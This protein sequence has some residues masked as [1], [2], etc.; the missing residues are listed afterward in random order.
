M[1]FGNFTLCVFF[2]R[3]FVI[4]AHTRFSLV[5]GESITKFE[6]RAVARTKG[7]QGT[8]ECLGLTT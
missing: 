2:Q 1:G 4:L 5:F 8:R 3:G 7:S 6:L